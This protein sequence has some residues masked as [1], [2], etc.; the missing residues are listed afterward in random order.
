MWA[1]KAI[2]DETTSNTTLQRWSIRGVTAQPIG[3][4]R[5]VFSRLVYF[6]H[7]DALPVACPSRPS[8]GTGWVMTGSR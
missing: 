3:T 2:N 5:R 4:V 8:V 1:D 7:S 6:A